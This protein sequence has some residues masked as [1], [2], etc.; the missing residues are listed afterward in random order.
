MRIR[1]LIVT[2]YRGGLRVSEALSLLPKALDPVAGSI[3]VLHGKGSRARTV[4]VDPGAMAV[5]ERWI[6]IRSKN[7]FGGRS[8]VFCTLKGSRLS[9]AYVRKMLPR[10]ARRAGIDKR[11]HAHGLRHT[12]AAQ[13]ASEGVPINVIYRQLGHSNVGMTSRYIDHISPT[14]DIEAM[15]ARKWSA[16]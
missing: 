8:P 16:G 12:R 1:A 15:R 11:V 2:L 10:M 4:G 3:R 5:I 6:Q 14:Q 13:L 9:P 7:G